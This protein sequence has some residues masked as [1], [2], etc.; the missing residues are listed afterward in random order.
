MKIAF[1]A[2]TS[3]N[4]FNFRKGLVGHFL[5]KGDEVLVLTPK[6][7]YTE[8]IVKWGTK[9]INTPLEGT[10]INPAKDVRYLNQLRRI[11]KKELPEA[12][13]SYTIKSNIYSCLAARRTSIP[14]ICNVSGLGTVFLVDDLVGK[15]AINLYRIAFRNAGF[16]FFQNQDDQN[17]FLSKVRIP[18]DKIGLLPGSGIDLTAYEYASPSFG[19]C[20]KFLMISRLIIEKGVREFA[21][22]ASNFENQ[23]D[24]SFTL[25]GKFD[26]MHARSIAKSELDQWISKGWIE[27][28][29]HSN[30][31]KDLIT[32][33]EVVVLPSYRE[34]TPRT[35]LEGA[36]MG[37][38]LLASNV[39][40]CK[41]VIDDGVNGFLFE[42]KNT[43]QLVSKIKLYL[44]LSLDERL[45]MARNSR[46]LAE[47][48]FD[49]K[50]V[51]A[52]YEKVIH[53]ISRP[54]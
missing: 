38:A 30:H 51:I 53:R 52:S 13:L 27:Y 1:V 15:F 49:E 32:G 14:V 45:E 24:V 11:F 6:D 9:W 37:K 35:L 50:I 3:W 25:V 34:G 39:P 19:N 41:E 43:K 4:I 44:S 42:A 47:E 17:L 28:L 8:E 36:A 23:E 48:K 40:G 18:K 31:I 21:E 2:N 10:G 33:H 22:A 5:A 20:T 12:V 29:P 46:E 54:T 26:E 16:V 7:E